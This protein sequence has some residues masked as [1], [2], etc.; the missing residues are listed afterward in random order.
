MKYIFMLFVATVMIFTACKKKKTPE[1]CYTCM[2]YDS[3]HSNVPF[4]TSDSAT[5][6]NATDTMC[7]YTDG[8]INY[9]MQTHH[10]VDTT[11]NKHDTLIIQFSAIV[12][13][14]D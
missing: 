12:C 4:Y 9:Y 6:E 3:S 7:G 1:H 14:Q 2:K 10:L 5:A 11:Y 8:T 13:N